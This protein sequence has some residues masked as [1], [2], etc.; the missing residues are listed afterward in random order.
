[1]SE[2]LDAA[3]RID[4]KDAMHDVDVA[5]VAERILDALRGSQCRS[6]VLG[7]RRLSAP[8]RE[9]HESKYRDLKI[10]LG[11]LIEAR[12]PG[13]VVDFR[14]PDVR[15]DLDDD[16]RIEVTR[17]PIFIAGRYR[18][19]SRRLS[20]S[21]WV[22]HFCRGRG[23]ESCGHTGT[24][25]GP[26]VEELLRDQLLAA[27]SGSELFFH[28]LGREDTDVRMLGDGRPFVVEVRDPHR[29]TLDLDALTRAVNAAAHGTAEIFGLVPVRRQVVRALKEARAVKRYRAWIRFGASPPTDAARRVE[30]LTSACVRQLSPARVMK[31]RGENV[32]RRRR[33]E[34]SR[35]LGNTPYEGIWE[36]GVESGMYIKELISGDRGRTSPSVSTALEIPCDCVALDVLAVQWQPPWE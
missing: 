14:T 21:R 20:A 34:L 22:H 8:T 29:R 4:G 9:E 10:L 30:S 6:F 36:V 33:I 26:S 12:R 31:R 23:C 2:D 17:A 15:I 3:K 24:I 16:M 25:C 7:F 13:L 27:V 35:W 1:M 19:M 28:A 32:E 11:R 18:K 5:S